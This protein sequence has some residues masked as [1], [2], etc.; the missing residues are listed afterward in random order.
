MRIALD[1]RF[2]GIEKECTE[3]GMMAR[4]YFGS[5][6]TFTANYIYVSQEMMD[7]ENPS[8]VLETEMKNVEHMAGI[9]D[10]DEALIMEAEQK[11]MAARDSVDR[12]QVSLEMINQKIRLLRGNGGLK[13]ATT[14]VFI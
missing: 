3:Y 2:A 12:A 5:E 9:Y 13:T 8:K 1:K 6:D 14:P 10:V 4:S 7:S 11:I